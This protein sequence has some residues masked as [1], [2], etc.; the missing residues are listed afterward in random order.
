MNTKAMPE[1]TASDVTRLRSKVMLDDATGCWNW[2]GHTGKTGYGN[3]WLSNRQILAHRASYAMAGLV[4]PDDAQLDHL[5]RNRACVRPDHLEP[6][7]AREN[8]LRSAGVSAQF[9][10]RDACGNGHPY[11]EANTARRKDGGRVCRQCKR[12]TA[13]AIY[14][15]RHPVLGGDS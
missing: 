12:E 2:T 7:T 8:T 1:F 4:I 15:R 3:F 13:R 5:C 11:D 9:A 10:R 6:V 14:A